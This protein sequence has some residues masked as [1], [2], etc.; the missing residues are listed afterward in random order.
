MS[1]ISLESSRRQF[2]THGSAALAAPQAGP[3][4]AA[5]RPH[6]QFMVVGDWGRDGAFH[7]RQV[8]AAMGEFQKSALVVSTGDNFYQRGVRNLGDRKW[9]SSF[10]RIYTNVPQ[11]W[12]AVLGNH[13]YGG[14]VEAQI[15][16]TFH[17]PRWR[18]PNYWFDFRLDAH[19]RPDVHLFYIDTVLWR[20]REKFPYRYLGSSVR[21]RD[22]AK[23]REWL[24]AALARSDAAIKLVFGHHPI[25]S[26]RTQGSYY[27]MADLD[28][29]LF[30]YGVTAYVNGHDHC[31]YH[32][33]APDWRGKA[34]GSMHYICSG[35][36]SQ[37]RP[38]Y[39]PCIPHGLVSQAN[40]V[41]R[42]QLGPREPYWHAFF[43]RS[44]ASPALDLKGG[45]A[46]F[47]A[48]GRSLDVRFIEPVPDPVTGLNWRQRYSGAVAIRNRAAI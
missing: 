27:G 21:K 14:N 44:D 10:Q 20:G 46:V 7:Q 28:A 45:F 19:A 40:C 23:Q 15:A 31:M 1:L 24:Q 47:E 30:D 35:A 6:L 4:W 38:V 29:L 3:A 43:T 5:E 18:M 2:I 34:A 9:E 41:S 13:D 22:Q 8:A 32:I 25:F 16:K 42:E 36:G 17:D 39:P 12:Y 37:M 33:S 26:V 11:R 48:T